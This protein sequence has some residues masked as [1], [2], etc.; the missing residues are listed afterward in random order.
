MVHDDQVDGG[1]R[2]GFDRW[3]FM[4]G[5][6]AHSPLS[7]TGRQ[8]LAGPRHLTRKYWFIIFGPL[9]VN[10]VMLRSFR[11]VLVLGGNRAQ[12]EV[13]ALPVM[14]LPESRQAALRPWGRHRSAYP[15]LFPTRVP[16]YRSGTPL[17]HA[18][19]KRP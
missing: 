12:S 11:T 13:C 1:S 18:G 4:V 3:W 7:S 2:H 19:N 17:S 6:P 10:E 9:H 14:P 16:G 5:L 15:F 8:A